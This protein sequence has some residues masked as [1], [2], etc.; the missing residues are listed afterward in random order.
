MTTPL[1]YGSVCSGIEAA[2]LAWHSLGWRAAWLSEIEPFPSA[3][4]AHHYPDVPNLGDMTK[5]PGLVRAG[6]IPAPD[7]LVG[8]TPCQAYSVA[9]LRGGLSDPRGA[10]TLAFVDLADAIDAVRSVRDAPPAIIVWENVPGVLSSKDNAFGCFLGGLAGESCELKPPGGGWANAGCVFGPARVVAWRVLDAQY[11]GVAQRRRRVFVVA[12]AREGFDPTAVLFEFEGVRRDTAPSREA[13]EDAARDAEAGAGRG[14]VEGGLSVLH[15]EVVSTIDASFC[16]LQGCSGQDANHGHSHLIIG[17]YGGNNQTGQI[18][19][20][21]ACRA[22]GGSGHGDFESETFIVGTM[23]SSDGGADVDHGMAGQLVPVV[24]GPTQITS[25]GNR[26]NPQPGDPC[27]TLAKGQHAPVVAFQGRGS[28]LDLVQDVVGTLTQNS[29]RASGGAPCIAFSAKDYGGDA[30]HD[31]APTLRGGG[32][33]TSHANGGVMPAIA[34][35]ANLSGTQHAASVDLAPSMGAKNPTAIAYQSATEFLPQ[36]SRVYSEH[37]KSPTLQAA[38]TRMGNRAPQVQQGMQVRRL[39]PVECERLQGFHDDYT[40]ISTWDG[41]RKMDASE[42]PEGCLSEGM[43]V[44]QTKKSGKWMVKDVDGPR[45]KAIGN[46]MAV[47][48]MAWI[49]RRIARALA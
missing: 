15:R 1:T 43:E 7:V 5:L 29:D 44:R 11:F 12:S 19:V 10:L 4:L 22:K 6:A 28:N 18:D 33:S 26:S 13:G 25:P 48:V 42:T 3:V 37:E 23:R 9:G 27:H 34:F 41:W 17:A 46:S 49:G 20:A 38:G 14:G 16:R 24:F 31:L 8:G 39:M 21:T 47:P 32:H 30:A 40:K 2:T 35:P 45:Y 36:S